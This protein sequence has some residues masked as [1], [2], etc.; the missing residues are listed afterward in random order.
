MI[1]HLRTYT[2]N[3]GM[4]DGWLELFHEK[5][6]PLLDEAGIKVESAWVND[7]RTQFVWIRSYGDSA[8]DIEKKE[9]AFYGADWWLANVDHVRSHLAHREIQLIESV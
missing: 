6:V 5:L 1:A 3:K 2:I 7:E 8:S 9:A 4:M